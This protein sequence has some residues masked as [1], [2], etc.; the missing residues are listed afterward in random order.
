[1]CGNTSFIEP[2]SSKI[3]GLET[4]DLSMVSLVIS[5]KIRSKPLKIEIKT[6]NKKPLT[7]LKV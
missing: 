7:Q 5:L 2:A 6:K 4:F 1:M 3:R